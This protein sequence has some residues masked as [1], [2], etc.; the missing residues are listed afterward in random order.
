MSELRSASYW[1]GH[2][3]V[4]LATV[5][6]VYLAA[7]AG[8]KQA[9]KLDLL[10]SDRGTYYVA[11]SL[12]QELKFNDEYMRG[13]IKN[14]EGKNFVFKEHVAGI[15]LNEFVFQAAQESESTFEIDP[16]LL[17]EVS[18]YYFATGTGIDQYYESNMASPASLMNVIKKQTE[19]L[20]TKNTLTR[21]EQYKNDLA[22]DLI[23]RG[24]PIE[25]PSN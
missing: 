25:I 15:R 2:L 4:I 6:G 19:I 13:F 14:T 18:N 23:S 8:F 12:Y 10:N 9:L 1:V 21:L 17:S 3:M 11:E 20:E 5:L 7:N 16:L 24:M 22:A